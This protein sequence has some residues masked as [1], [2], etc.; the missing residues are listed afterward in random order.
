MNVDREASG[1]SSSERLGEVASY[2]HNRPMILVPP[3]LASSWQI[4]SG[5]L[6]ND[7]PLKEEK[8]HLRVHNIP[9]QSVCASRTCMPLADNG[10]T[11]STNEQGR[12][13]KPIM[14][15]D[16]RDDDSSIAA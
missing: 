1:T 11:V 16:N 6:I 8:S 4:T 12:Q 2:P 10:S 7:E 5:L 3:P 14:V 15:C 9:M 13:S